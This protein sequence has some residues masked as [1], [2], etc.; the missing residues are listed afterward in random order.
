MFESIQQALLGIQAAFQSNPALLL[1][2]FLTG[3]ILIWLKYRVIRH[4]VRRSKKQNYAGWDVEATQG[5]RKHPS[6]IGQT[7]VLIMRPVKVIPLALFCLCFFG[8]GALFV[9]SEGPE[10][11]R[12]W[13]TVVAGAVFC[14]LSLWMIAFSF[15]RIIYDG[16]TIERRA[17]FRAPVSV[18]LSSLTGVR[19]INKTITGGVYLRFQSGQKL[20]VVP[21]MSGYRQLLQKL[22]EKDPKLALLLRMIP[23]Q[24]KRS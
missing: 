16:E 10:G 13:F 7:D 5:Q 11:P 17:L 8:G 15:T 12:A 3:L 9:A 4:S 21:R 23:Q 6:G 1:G 22:A 24:Q 18:P 14:L 20:R 2:V 19:P